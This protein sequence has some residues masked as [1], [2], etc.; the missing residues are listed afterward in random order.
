MLLDSWLKASD[1]RDA[2]VIAD[3]VW[4]RMTR[5]GRKLY[6]QGQQVDDAV[7]KEQLRSVAAMFMQDN[8]PR[9]RQLGVV[10]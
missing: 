10:E 6:H 9:W 5:I 3:G 1:R 2:T 7:A 4:Q 8:L